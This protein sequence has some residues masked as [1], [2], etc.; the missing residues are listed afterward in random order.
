MRRNSGHS[1]RHWLPRK[2]KPVQW[3]GELRQIT[4]S[5]PGVVYQILFCTDGVPVG[6]FFSERSMEMFGLDNS[7]TDVFERFTAGVHPDDRQG[8]LDSVALATRTGTRWNYEGRYIKS[9]GDL[10]WFETNASPAVTDTGIILTGVILDISARKKME[11]AL[12][13]SESLYGTLADEAQDLIYI[14]DRDDRVVYVN[15]YAAQMMGRS[16][17]DIIGQAPYAALSGG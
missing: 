9:T 6:I 15:R 8:F 17:E 16:R 10:V 13:R 14:I 5:V 3:N 2:P 7:L 11:D 4:A 1:T 12:R